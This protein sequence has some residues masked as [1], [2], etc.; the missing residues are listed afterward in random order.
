MGK[1]AH[2]L[3]K[4]FLEAHKIPVT[5]R[6][7]ILEAWQRCVKAG[8]NSTQVVP[9]KIDL[10]DL[11]RRRQRRA[12]L[13]KLAM[14]IMESLRKFLSHHPHIVM[15]FDEDVICLVN[16]CDEAT[17]ENGASIN[18]LEGACWSEEKMGACG[19]GSAAVTGRP[20]IVFGREHYIEVLAEWTCMG[21][22]IRHPNGQVMGILDLAMPNQF[23]YHHTF[24]MLL[25]AVESIEERMREYHQ[26]PSLQRGPNIQDQAIEFAH[27]I[28][29]PLTAVKGVIQLMASNQLDQKF[30]PYLEIALKELDRVTDLLNC[31]MSLHKPLKP[32][33]QPVDLNESLNRLVTLMSPN[34]SERGVALFFNPAPESLLVRADPRLL[35]QVGQNLVRNAVQAMEDGGTLEIVTSYTGSMATAAFRDTGPGIPEEKLDAIFHPFVTSHDH[36]VGVGLALC[37]KI[38]RL[39]GGKISV[40]SELGK[41]TCFE[42]KIPRQS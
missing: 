41:G 1:L 24:G 27:E 14:P 2:Q 35:H 38:V 18:V 40:R 19:A 20:V 6:P 21:A 22:P 12:G 3:W 9:Q 30:K 13:I 39:H 25:T 8:V 31:F 34:A 4:E 11:K 15:L 7:E 37:E 32:D 33:F 17:R 29:N 36:G 10:V 16:L 23:V 28:R 42:I 26:K 5:L